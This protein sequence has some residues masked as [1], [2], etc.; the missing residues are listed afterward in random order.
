MIRVSRLPSGLA[1]CESSVRG[2]F[3]FISKT[4]GQ[5]KAEECG[6]RI[7]ILEND[8]GDRVRHIGLG[9]AE[10]VRK[11]LLSSQQ[12]LMR[13]VLCTGVPSSTVTASCEWSCHVTLPASHHPAQCSEQVSYYPLCHGSQL[14]SRARR[15][16]SVR[17]TSSL[18]PDHLKSLC[19]HQPAE[20]LAAPC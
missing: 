10:L 4:L 7:C 15:G 1:V 8:S 3:S 12:E 13:G 2:S 18:L 9:W 17:F 20:F 14:A 11:P 19:L 6:V 16:A 5:L